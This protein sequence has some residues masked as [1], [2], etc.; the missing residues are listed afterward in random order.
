M[1]LSFC[2]E[3]IVHCFNPCRR[4]PHGSWLP[5]TR[6]PISFLGPRQHSDLLLDANIDA[7]HTCAGRIARVNANGVL[8]GALE[9]W[10]G[11]DCNHDPVAALAGMTVLDLC[12]WG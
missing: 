9:H 5:P 4:G 2:K 1:F 8:S 7:P 6:A 3:L 12:D 11:F 10:D